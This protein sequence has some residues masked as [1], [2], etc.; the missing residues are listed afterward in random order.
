MKRLLTVVAVA[1]ALLIAGC[2][3]S[4]TPAST[5]D[6]SVSQPTTDEFRGGTVLPLKAAPELGLRSVDGKRVRMADLK[7]KVVLITFIYTHCPDICQLITDSMRLTKKELGA[8]GAKVA[9]VAVSVDPEGD[10]PASVRTF[11]KDHQVTGQMDYLMGTRAQLEPVW[12][13]WAVAAERNF[14]NPA[15]VEHSGV[16]WMVDMASN[17]AVYFPVSSVKVADM[18]HDV[19]VLLAK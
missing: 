4:S 14:D 2:G 12:K 1:G 8:D 5:D 19:K 18:V 10:T 9:L 6:A 11:L 3:G 7:G 13:A 17:R 16:V 15:L